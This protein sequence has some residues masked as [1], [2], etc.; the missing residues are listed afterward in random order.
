MHGHKGLDHGEFRH[1]VPDGTRGRSIRGIIGLIPTYQ[2]NRQIRMMRIEIRHQFKRKE[3]GN[4]RSM[5]YA[6][7]PGWVI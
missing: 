4:A 6:E 7:T 5:V 3:K 2:A 1:L